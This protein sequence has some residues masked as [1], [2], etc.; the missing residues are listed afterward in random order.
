MSTLTIHIQYFT[1][2]LASLKRQGKKTEPYIGKEE[3]KLC[4]FI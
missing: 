4:L 1:G 2:A 3:V